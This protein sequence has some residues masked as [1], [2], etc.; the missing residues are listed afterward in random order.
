M[1]RFVVR[2][3]SLCLA[4]LFFAAC[5]GNETPTPAPAEIGT[6]AQALTIDPALSLAI[7]EEVVLEPFTLERVMK[8]IIDTSGVP[9]VTPL[10][11]YQQWWDTQNP[12]PGLNMGPH[13]DDEITN[14]QP[15]LNSFPWTCPR[16][17]GYQAHIDPFQGPPK[18]HLYKPIGIF[19]RFDLTPA[20]GA[21]CGE[22]RIIFGMD[23][24]Q[25]DHLGR[26][27]IIF[28][29]VLPNPD[30]SQGIAACLP[31]AQFWAELSDEPNPLVRQS[32]LEKFFF[33]GIFG[34]APAVHANHY[35]SVLSDQ[36]YGCSTG[37]IR[38]NQFSQDPWG[39]REFR[40][41]TDCRCGKCFLLIVPTTVK[42]NPFGQLFDPQFVHAASPALQ[43]AM[44]NGVST[45]GVG[46]VND[47]RWTVP[48]E[49]NS[50]ESLS[51]FGGPDDYLNIFLNA[52]A[53]DPSFFNAVDAQVNAVWSGAYSVDQIVTRAQ[54][55]SCA[56][57]HHT[58]NS[59]DI[60]NGFLW[61][62]SLA[63]VHVEE[64]VQ[65]GFYPI[66]PALQNEFL[67]KR[68][69]LLED[70]LASG[71]TASPT[72]TKCEIRL[73]QELVV[74]CK[75]AAARRVELRSF[76]PSGLEKLKMP[77]TLRTGTLGGSRV[78]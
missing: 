5:G 46:G 74:D 1:R 45:L 52:A 37:Q 33:H 4:V 31:I 2:S 53:S 6:T 78:H 40:V 15:S 43:N 21:H 60:G 61:P 76:K 26:N 27:T 64:V 73:P 65:G 49:T 19:N 20:N 55:Q 10:S 41:V 7:T 25:P 39:L 14:G 56:G 68:K 44:I 23:P 71:G 51:M 57:C 67:P 66:S 32:H 42:D 69:Q 36:G 72:D 63:F 3:S 75:T 12:A 38:T 35:G 30:P 50:G 62:D 13:C 59:A 24:S 54:T 22:Y 58:T 34:F 17:E 11:L 29:A 8:Q 70:F 16:A 48:N 77:S 18:A 28:E 47:V 9:G